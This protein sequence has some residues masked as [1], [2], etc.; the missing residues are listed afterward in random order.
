MRPTVKALDIVTLRAVVEGLICNEIKF[1]EP[2]SKD[3]LARNVTIEIAD[4]H[5]G[6]LKISGKSVGELTP[7]RSGN[8]D[9]FIPYHQ[10]KE[11]L[12]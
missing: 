3:P 9:V 7:S 2:V 1:N 6:S 8:A 12:P 10:K 4:V 11:E 5:V